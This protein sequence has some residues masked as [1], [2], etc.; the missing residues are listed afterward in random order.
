[1][2]RRCEGGKRQL[3]LRYKYLA[4]I[5]DKSTKIM[6]QIFTFDAKGELVSVKD[7]DGFPQD[8]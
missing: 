1:M 7:V 4:K 3:V 5:Q 2:G 8:W 6:N